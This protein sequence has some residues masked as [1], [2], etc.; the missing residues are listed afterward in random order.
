MGKYGKRYEFPNVIW[1]VTTIK[2]GM[3][4]DD[5]QRIF[6]NRE[7]AIDWIKKNG[8]CKKSPDDSFWYCTE[9]LL[10]HWLKFC[11]LPKGD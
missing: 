2:G 11:S 4:R 10:Y 1:I 7:S 3:I 5:G 8:G 9:P 6:K